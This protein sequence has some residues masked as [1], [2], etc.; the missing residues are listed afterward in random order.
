M[1]SVVKS[2]VLVVALV[3][4]GEHGVQG[5]DVRSPGGCVCSDFTWFNN[6]GFVSTCQKVL[7]NLR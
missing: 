2:L 7:I 4:L 3:L 5:D 6:G 1:F